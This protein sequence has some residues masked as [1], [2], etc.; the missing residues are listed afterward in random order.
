MKE[1]KLYAKILVNIILFLL[2]LIFIIFLLPKIIFFFMPFVIG[3][4]ISMIANP[5]V[6][7]M[8]KK[9]KIVRKHSSA[10]IIITV[11]AAIVGILYGAGVILY[12]EVGGLLN[13]LPDLAD[14]IEQQFMI[15]EGNLSKVL[16]GLPEGMHLSL[17]NILSNLDQ[18]FEEF[19]VNIEQWGLDRAGDVAKNVVQWLFSAI[20]TILSA[21]FFIAE[22]ENILEW[23]CEVTP[24]FLQDQMQVITK[25]FKTAVGGYFRAQ[26]KIMLVIILILFIG[27]ELLKVKY[28]FL[29]A[30][31]IAFLDFLPVFGTGTILWPWAL[32]ELVSGDYMNA[33]LLMVIYLVCQLIKQLLQP[34]MVGDSIGLSPLATLIFLYIGYKVKGVIGM[35][36]GI[37]IGMVVINLFQAGVFDKTIETTKLIITKIN[38]FRKI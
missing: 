21:Y 28:S 6:R 37:P 34:K 1:P 9:I 38:E 2:G 17:N 16:K 32:I 31:V 13:D 36:I 24:Q 22:R 3:W 4:L 8:E 18:Y 10:I 7:F 30:F 29:L 27:L 11:L 33:A 23:L 5:L 35:I 15:A 14:S 20:I 19:L 25:N 26:F 12:R